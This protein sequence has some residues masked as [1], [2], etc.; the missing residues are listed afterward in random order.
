MFELQAEA[1]KKMLCCLYHQISPFLDP[2]SF[3][4]F[5]AVGALLVSTLCKVICRLKIAVYDIGKIDHKGFF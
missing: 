1:H 2:F 3:P 4:I 5:I